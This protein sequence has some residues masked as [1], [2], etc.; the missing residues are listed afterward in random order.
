MMKHS[1][2][3]ASSYR[4]QITNSSA[5]HFDRDHALKQ[6]TRKAANPTAEPL[7]VLD[8]CNYNIVTID[9]IY[10]QIQTQPLQ[11]LVVTV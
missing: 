3:V 7:I 10:H 4:C 9:D 1:Y 5:F 8:R 2:V 6:I 11:N